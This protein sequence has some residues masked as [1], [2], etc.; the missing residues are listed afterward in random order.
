[1]EKEFSAI[2][3][4]SGAGGVSEALKD[5]FQIKCAIEYDPVIA[6]TYELNHGKDHLLVEDITL[7]TNE[8]LLNLVKLDKSLDL[9]VGTP[10][11]QGFSKHSRKSS[12]NNF[13][14]RNKLILE[15]IRVAEAVSPKFIFFENVENILKYSIFHLFLKRLANLDRYGYKK[16]QN[17]PSYHICFN[18]VNASDYGVP[19][20]RKRL[21]L[22][23]KKIENFPNINAVIKHP[24]GSLPFVTSPLELWPDKQPA[25]S[26]GEYWDQFSLA[27][28]NAGETDPNDPLH[29]CRSLSPLNLR[30][31][32]S[33]KKNGGSRSEWPQDLK[34]DC[35]KKE[36]I[37]FGDVYGRMNRNEYAPTITCGCITYSKGRFGH[38]TENRAISLREAALLQTFPYNYKFTGQIDG[39]EYKG[40]IDQI[41]KQIGN[42]VPVNLAK[43]FVKIIYNELTQEKIICSEKPDNIIKMYNLP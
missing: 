42:A 32:E 30:R 14:D 5:F 4:F 29:K 12:N 43:A 3:L 37:S 24:R 18:V 11:C 20:K 6:K 16:N 10:P 19:Q 13:D 34:L 26:I 22:L 41:A 39:S 28:L 21:V 36:N 33:T 40:S 23:A 15:V 31:I 27:H 9:L 8:R 38:P 1:M 7:I 17:K 35:H 2:D 25:L